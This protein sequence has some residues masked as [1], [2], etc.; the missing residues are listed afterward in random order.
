MG[1]N[2]QTFELKV[3]WIELKFDEVVMQPSYQLEYMDPAPNHIN[4]NK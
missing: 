1:S 4:R 3:N 2:K